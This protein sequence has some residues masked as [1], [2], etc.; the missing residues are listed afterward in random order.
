MLSPVR[1]VLPKQHLELPVLHL[2]A[3]HVLR[4]LLR[5][6]PTFVLM[7]LDVVSDSLAD[8]IECLMHT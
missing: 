3:C 6:E 1:L 4:F 2:Q 7:T 5:E 8:A